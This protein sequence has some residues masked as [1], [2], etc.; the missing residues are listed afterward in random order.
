MV[1]C[2]GA[3]QMSVPCVYVNENWGY[4]KMEISFPFQMLCFS[5]GKL[6]GGVR[7]F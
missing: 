4:L 2:I 5:V 7:F 1:N 6:D 3:T